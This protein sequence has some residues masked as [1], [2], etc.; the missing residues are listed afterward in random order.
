[1]VQKHLFKHAEFVRVS[2]VQ[3]TEQKFNRRRQFQSGLRDDRGDRQ[4]SARVEHCLILKSDSRKPDGGER[5]QRRSDGN[6][7]ASLSDGGGS[8]ILDLRWNVYHD[9]IHY[10]I[11]NGR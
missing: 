1:M 8:S 9:R 10:G 5:R 11:I 6:A 4:F 7:Y 3:R 2:N